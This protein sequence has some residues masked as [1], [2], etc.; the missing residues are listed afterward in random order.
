MSGK[1]V[2]L[3][4]AL[5]HQIAAG[6]VVERP[7]SIVKELLENALDAGATA[8]R[9]ELLKGGCGMIRLIDNGE[10][11][12]QDDVPKAFKRYA[13]SKIYQFDDIYEVSTFG[14]RGEALPSIASIAR[15][16]MTTRM[17]G[18]ISG[19]RIVVDAGRIEKITETGCPEGTSITVTQIFDPVPVRKKFLKT[20]TTEQGYC[21][22][23]ITRTALAH[24]QVRISVMANGRE[25]LKIP[26]TN[27]LSER[28]AL[29]LGMDFMD[30]LLPVQAVRENLQ[31]QGFI[32]R[33]P[34][35]RSHGRHLY[36]FVNRRYIRDYLLNHAIMT[37][38]RG[39]IE[40]RRYPA[41]V[42]LIDLPPGDVDVN[43]HPAKLEV[44][45]RHP[46]GIY[47]MIVETLAQAL[48]QLPQS[49][50]AG[51]ARNEAIGADFRRP[52]DYGDRIEEALKRY[53]LSSATGKLSFP[54]AVRQGRLQSFS[55][56]LRQ[57]AGEVSTE[58]VSEPFEPLKFSNLE[59]LGQALRTYLVFSAA[60]QVILLDQHAAHE[61]I[62]FEKLTRRGGS[63]GIG[64]RLL[65]PE[66]LN[67]SPKDLLFFE[68]SMPL[69][70]EAGIEAESFGGN[71]VVIKSVPV[72]FSQM[73]IR[74]LIMDLLDSFSDSDRLLGLK[75]RQDKI[76]RL[77]ACKAAVKANHAL[78]QPEAAALC[79]DLDETPFAATCPHGRPVYITL[80]LGEL[81]KRF[82][83]R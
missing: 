36:S 12:A 54:E 37:A 19:T 72:I 2:I 41:V 63:Q 27:D 62:L 49:A 77:L 13:T 65:L 38:Y 11:F 50:E 58:T 52:A 55:P 30:H 22:D 5:T 23:V 10:G 59:Y 3:P 48:A 34:F 78:T 8:V 42:L 15:V 9:I 61:R 7:A 21:L 24:P 51:H 43:V 4:E 29:I 74:D 18:A 35:T 45:F 67:L 68:E 46:R 83:R 1:I 20:E 16:E 44:R 26:A 32:S 76:F 53:R 82:K 79:R 25:V 17:S 14:F 80:G 40:A 73:D 71:S 56:P 60:D 66:V 69:L 75:D 64:Q 70:Q 57:P 33:P 47:G 28:M 6:E 31:M 39:M 81:E